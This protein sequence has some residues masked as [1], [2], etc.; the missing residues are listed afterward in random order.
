MFLSNCKAMFKILA[1]E[2][3]SSEVLK[4][5]LCMEHMTRRASLPTLPTTLR[6][7]IRELVE[8]PLQPA[9]NP[10]GDAQPRTRRC[11]LCGRKKNRKSSARCILCAGSTQHSL[12]LCR[13][14]H[15]LTTD[16]KVLLLFYIYFVPWSKSQIS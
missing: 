15:H 7:R 6:Y 11:C 4:K 9:A 2:D 16:Y 12:V 1:G 8:Q 5:A 14:T 10:D 13:M 3:G